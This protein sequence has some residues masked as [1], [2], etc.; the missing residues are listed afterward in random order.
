MEL[1]NANLD[2]IV[3]II[4][5]Q[6]GCLKDFSGLGEKGKNKIEL[7]VPPIPKGSAVLIYETV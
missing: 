6:F 4:S 2:W 1:S 3:R 5:N 7:V